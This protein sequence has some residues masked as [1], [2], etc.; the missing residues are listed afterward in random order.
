MLASPSATTQ[1]VVAT[2]GTV[3]HELG[4]AVYEQGIAPHLWGTNAGRGIMPY[5]HESQSKYLENIVGRR[6][7]VMPAL[8][9][10]IAAHLGARRARDVGE[11]DPRPLHPGRPAR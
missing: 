1:S 10:I 11:G 9:D 6:E 4:H 3:L 5:I 8:S 2:I 7:D